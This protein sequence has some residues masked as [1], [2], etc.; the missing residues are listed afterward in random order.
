M[1]TVTPDLGTIITSARVRRWIYAAYVVLI[2]ITGAVQVA[3]AAL[4]TGQP[5]WLVATLAVVA[6]L[7]VPVGGLA[8]ANTRTVKNAGTAD[9]AQVPDITSLPDEPTS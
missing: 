7:G 9:G 5:N 2:I 6:Y 3:F 4:E 1:T 8:I